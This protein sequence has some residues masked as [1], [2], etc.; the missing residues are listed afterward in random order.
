MY[1]DGYDFALIDENGNAL[2]ACKD[3]HIQTKNFDSSNILESKL[4]YVRRTFFQ[5][6]VECSNPIGLQDE[7]TIDTT[8]SK[9]IYKDNGVLYLPTTYKAKGEKTK[10]IVYCK[11]GASKVESAS[12]PI[13]NS[14][15]YNVFR[16]LLTKGYAVMCADGVPNQL[17]TELGI[18]ERTTGNY[19]AVQSARR[20]YELVVNNYNIDEKGCYL[21]GYS[22]GGHNAL[23]LLDLSGIPFICAC[24]VSP[25]VS[26]QWHQWNIKASTTAGGVTYTYGARLNIARLFGFPSVTSDAELN[27][28]Q[29]EQEKVQGYDPW[30]RNVDNVYNNFALGTTYGTNLYKLPADFDLSTLTMKKHMKCPVHIWCATNDNV[31]GSDVMRVFAKAIQNAGC[32]VG[33]T[34]Y[35]SGSHSLQSSGTAI[36][37][38]TENG[39]T[40]N[41]LPLANEIS[42]YLNQNGGY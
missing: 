35:T 36:G 28:L 42:L 33:L 10:L 20:L 19:I 27:A 25:V 22:Q 7:V 12:D 9:V 23:N 11:H 24:L 3:G 29:F 41:L 5:Y 21:Y 8:H 2:I 4:P 1:C 16:Y 18:G 14:L 38:Y 34:C 26:M 6:D 17:V 39:E 13:M 15:D 30:T 32:A 31:L 37:T 40:L